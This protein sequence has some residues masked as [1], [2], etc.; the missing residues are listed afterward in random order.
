MSPDV[1]KHHM[2]NLRTKS[3]AIYDKTAKPLPEVK[4]GDTVRVR[5]NKIWSP[6]KLVSISDNPRSYTLVAPSGRMIV[7]NRKHLLKTSEQGIFE[8]ER[9]RYQCRNEEDEN[10]NPP[11]TTKPQLVTTNEPKTAAIS[12]PTTSRPIGNASRSDPI[13][14]RSGRIS[15]PPDRL[16]YKK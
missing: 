6:A 7:R 16:N 13:V 12:E 9:I 2:Y 8:P 5:N 14:T 15:R 3:K 10:T 11:V 4:P 1:V